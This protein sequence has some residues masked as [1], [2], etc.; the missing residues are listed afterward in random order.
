M[1]FLPGNV[2][3][4]SVR[5]VDHATQAPTDPTA[6]RLVLLAPD[7]RPGEGSTYT[8]GGAMDTLCAAITRLS[9]GSYRADVVIPV[10]DAKAGKWG[11]AWE[12]D[13]SVGS[14]TPVVG[15]GETFFVV[16]KSAV[17]GA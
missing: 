15:S 1:A 8:Y 2:V 5:F 12:G 3:A 14:L 9:A 4:L 11:V 17:R 10:S 7:Q 16:T 6:V 13:G